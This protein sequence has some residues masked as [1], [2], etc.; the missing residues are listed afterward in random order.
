MAGQYAFREQPLCRDIEAVSR[1]VEGTGF[2]RPDEI[3]VAA[4]LVEECLDK[5]PSSGYS[6]IFADGASGAL[7]GYVCYGSIPCTL[8]SYDLY[9]IAVDQGSQGHGL[10]KILVARTEEAVRRLGG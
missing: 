10:G 9:W 1:L 7:Q 6:F 5:G 4:E 2:F 3:L 8:G